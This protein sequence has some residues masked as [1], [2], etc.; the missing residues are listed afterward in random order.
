MAARIHIIDD[1][2]ASF[3]AMA[4][5]LRERGHV[6]NTGVHDPL[7]PDLVLC[8]ARHERAMELAGRRRGALVALVGAGDVR[9]RDA[10]LA[11]GFDGYIALPF[12]AGSFADEVEAFLPAAAPALLVV[13]DDAFML[14]VLADMV[15]QEGWRVLTASSGEQ[16]LA[17]L[18]REPVGVVV[19]DHFMPGM[20]GA[21]LLAQVQRLYP[22][23]VRILLSGEVEEE[24]IRAALRSGA[25]DR[26]FAKPWMGEALVAALREAAALQQRRASV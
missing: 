21:A 3:A 9:E 12:E 26:F 1:D 7:P 11:A 2:P 6:V 25:A 15:E 14:E 23:S 24:E 18:A 4:R 19:S 20:T 22:A 13:D 5:L 17:R 16:A 10:L 8:C